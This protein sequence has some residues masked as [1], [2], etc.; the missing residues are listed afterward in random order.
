MIP[1][2]DRDWAAIVGFGG[3][4]PVGVTYNTGSGGAFDWFSQTLSGSAGK[5][6]LMWANTSG[7]ATAMVYIDLDRFF[8]H[9]CSPSNPCTYYTGLRSGTLADN[10]FSGDGVNWSTNPST[11]A[12]TFFELQADGYTVN[13]VKICIDAAGT[14]CSAD[15][16]RA[17]AIAGTCKLNRTTYVNF[18]SNTPVNCSATAPASGSDRVTNEIL[19]SD[20][21]VGWTGNFTT[22]DDDSIGYTAAGAGG[23]QPNTVYS[24][25]DSFVTHTSGTT[26]CAI[27][28]TT[29]GT[30]G[31]T[32]PLAAYTGGTC[33]TAGTTFNDGPNLVWTSV[34]ASNSSTSSKLEGQG[35]GFDVLWYS[36]TQG[37]SRLN[38]R[39]PKIYRGTGNALAAGHPKN[40]NYTVCTQTAAS[41]QALISGGYLTAGQDPGWYPGGY[42]AWSAVNTCTDINTPCSCDIVDKFTLHDGG[43][44]QKSYLI[45]YSPTSA[46]SPGGWF[47]HQPQSGYDGSNYQ[48][49]QNYT[50]DTRSLMVYPCV[51]TGGASKC[52]GHAGEGYQYLYKG[53]DQSAHDF[54]NPNKA[55]GTPNP[56]WPSI[57][58]GGLPGDHHSS[59]RAQYPTHDTIDIL[60]AFT[61]IPGIG[62]RAGP[63]GSYT[64]PLY[65][66]E[67]GGPARGPQNWPACESNNSCVFIN[68]RFAHSWNTNASPQFSAQNAMGVISYDGKLEALTTDMMGTRG[69]SS[70]D[71]AATQSYASGAFINPH[72]SS[73]ANHST[74]Q[75]Q[76]A[77]SQTSAGTQPNWANC[78][79]PGD[80]CQDGTAPNIFN[81]VNVGAPCNNLRADMSRES[82]HTYSLGDR[83]LMIQGGNANDIFE[84]T[85]CN[86]ACITG[87]GSFDFSSANC[88]GYGNCTALDGN[89]TWKHLGE[90]ECR[91]DIMLIDLTSA[92]P[93]P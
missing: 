54:E 62:R 61:D 24:Y 27:W 86:G 35:P 6:M 88:P 41:W 33:P 30:S 36:P 69:S 48:N 47:Q 85:A 5:G 57:P 19:P 68:H 91:S 63:Y 20:Y 82:S 16:V 42:T 26:H 50:W 59:A 53:S 90:N 64:T 43:A 45:G 81:W 34:G 75:L 76:T 93:K 46:L 79:N 80:T 74:Y 49:N 28:A 3:G 56:G 70:D 29:G 18:T 52:D 71:W 78:Q 67:V 65:S 37:C 23:W 66:E 4:N 83:S 8:A 60:M 9:T 21:V 84:I 89:V 10:R 13:K 92:A 39:L 40:N 55:D 17:C 51:T 58:D 87:S 32:D 12:N 1:S 31:A 77:T 44:R 7:S 72:S 14:Q 15:N 11:P 22:T 38:S 2:T 73:N 25:P